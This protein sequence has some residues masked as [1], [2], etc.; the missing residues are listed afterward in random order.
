MSKVSLGSGFAKKSFF[1][2]GVEVFFGK[3]DEGAILIEEVLGYWFFR[4]RSLRS[5]FLQK[6]P[7]C[8]FAPLR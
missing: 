1:L 4:V 5:T 8:V 7:L 6:K 2:Q 3:S